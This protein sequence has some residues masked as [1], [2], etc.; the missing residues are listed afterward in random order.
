MIILAIMI[1][2][3]AIMII[4]LTSKGL[5]DGVLFVICRCV[6]FAFRITNILIYVRITNFS[7]NN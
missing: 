6:I 3:L 2:W 5:R 4:Q 7:S 1:I